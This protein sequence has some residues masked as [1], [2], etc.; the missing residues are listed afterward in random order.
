MQFKMFII[1]FSLL[2][3]ICVTELTATELNKKI[4]GMWRGGIEI[5]DENIPDVVFQIFQNSS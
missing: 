2:F 3:G 4:E 1:C 5:P